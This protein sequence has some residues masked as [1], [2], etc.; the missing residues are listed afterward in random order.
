[1][2]EIYTFNNN[3]ENWKI[4]ASEITSI[5]GDD[6]KF[7]ADGNQ[8]IVF[9][10]DGTVIIDNH[11]DILNN[12]RTQNDIKLVKDLI[13]DTSNVSIKTPNSNYVIKC[14]DDLLSKYL[15]VSNQWI[16]LSGDGYKID[17]TPET[18]NSKVLLNFSVTYNISEIQNQKI[19]F[20]L[21]RFDNYT[22][23]TYIVST[24]NV[25]GTDFA[26]GIQ[27]NYKFMYLD[28]PNTDTNITYY[29][30]VS[31]NKLT[32]DISDTAILGYDDNKY[33]SI[34]AYQI[35]I[36][37][38]SNTITKA[39]KKSIDVSFADKINNK[40]LFNNIDASKVSIDNSFSISETGTINNIIDVSSYIYSTTGTINLSGNII[41][42]SNGIYNLGSES[43]RFKDVYVSNNSLYFGDKRVTVD[44][45]GKLQIMSKKSDDTEENV[46]INFD[47]I[48]SEASFGNV[49]LSNNLIMSNNTNIEFLSNIDLSVN[50]QLNILN[51]I[52]INKTLISLA[53]N[54]E[55]IVYNNVLSINNIN[56]NNSNNSN[57]LIINVSNIDISSIVTQDFINKN[58]I[59]FNN[60]TIKHNLDISSLKITN[61]INNGTITSNA[62]TNLLTDLS[63]NT[64][65]DISNGSITLNN[66][67]I[68]I[69][70]LKT[71]NLTTNDASINN[72]LSN[73]SLENANINN[74]IIKNNLN[75][76]DVSCNEIETS[77]NFYVN[78][79]E[80]ENDKLTIEASNV[81]IEGS[82]IVDGSTITIE[83]N[84]IEISSNQ[85]KLASNESTLL[86]ESGIEISNN[87]ASIKY[88]NTNDEIEISSNLFEVLKDISA[89]NITIVN[90]LNY[91]GTNLPNIS[92]DI[93]GT[94][95]DLSLTLNQLNNQD[96]YVLNLSDV[97]NLEKQKIYDA[98][99]VSNLTNSL[100]INDISFIKN[101]NTY[102]I[103]YNDLSF[104]DISRIF[105]SIT[106]RGISLDIIDNKVVLSLPQSLEPNT[107]I[108]FSGVTITNSLYINQHD[109]SIA[110]V[111]D[112]QTK[113]QNMKN[114]GSSSSSSSQITSSSKFSVDLNFNNNDNKNKIITYEKNKNKYIKTSDI[115]VSS[116]NN[117]HQNMYV[118]LNPFKATL[119]QR[120][121]N[122]NGSTN[123][124]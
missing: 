51:D 98:F 65:I 56:L 48:I 59:S 107:N 7:Y 69:S 87:I 18:K 67:D 74:L 62:I 53:D 89:Q 3:K 110:R 31:C 57:N 73:V 43:K 21:K 28:E 71:T 38:I 2:P 103:S 122:N 11:L 111:S 86:N 109:V 104:S 81:V 120:I 90:N 55:T 100:N 34:I 25:L 32:N 123:N 114:E 14:G 117:L 39:A 75:V 64:K 118:Y 42:V 96:G 116:E 26:F 94:S 13:L 47:S 97:T 80:L 119:H 40:G 95:T 6:L 66:N 36:P 4:N 63:V 58:D 16:D 82:L 102:T 20:R 5:S 35:Y 115:V 9:N 29:L 15:D 91:L 121:L 1:M 52:S 24:E 106:T 105:S 54:I 84:N 85:I 83:S 72:L 79:I 23:S 70:N 93:S 113:L 124:S 60:V 33:N 12:V 61:L 44:E 41:T 77:G 99:D 8:N 27:D 22:N 101:D 49:E 46:Y 68:N 10:T 108:E 45:S 88:K 92:E 19:N 112:L 17:I 76:K 37:D 30:E 78:K 50:E